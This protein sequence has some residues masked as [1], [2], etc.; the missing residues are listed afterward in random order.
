MGMMNTAAIP[1]PANGITLE[2]LWDAI[3]APSE[4]MAANS[5]PKINPNAA[6]ITP[7]SLPTDITPTR[8]ITIRAPRGALYHYWCML[9]TRVRLTTIAAIFVAV[10]AVSGK[11]PWPK[12][13]VDP[14]TAEVTFR[15]GGGRIVNT[16]EYEV[17]FY[18]AGT[19]F[20]KVT[21]LRNCSSDPNK[22]ERIPPE[23]MKAIF[24][25][26]DDSGFFRVQRID[27]AGILAD[28][29]IGTITYRDNKG[30]HEVVQAWRRLPAV[31]AAIKAALDV[32]KVITRA[33]A[34]PG[35]TPSAPQS[36]AAG[37]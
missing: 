24:D 22:A 28:A 33:A 1:N 7:Y 6:H 11:L 18:G 16:P 20:A 36:P 14:K 3:P 23:R 10:L 4:P 26:L 17:T 27:P 35:T 32:D 9:A 37:R 30:A 31:V 15:S 13:H 21:C 34:T 2:P 29:D 19:G 12:R 8:L 5:R 25:A